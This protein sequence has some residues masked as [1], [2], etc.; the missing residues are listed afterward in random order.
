[1]VFNWAPRS[2]LELSFQKLG[3]FEIKDTI[4]NLQPYDVSYV[5]ILITENNENN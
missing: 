3:D 4:C 5:Y 2:L 1:M